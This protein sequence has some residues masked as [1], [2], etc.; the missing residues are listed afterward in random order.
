MYRHLD[1]SALSISMQPSRFP[2]L[3]LTLEE[4]SFMKYFIAI[5]LVGFVAP[6]LGLAQDKPVQLKDLKDKASYSVGLNI[7]TNFKRQNVEL[8]PEALLAGVKDAL[9]G[10]KPLLTQTEVREV[11]A[12]WSKE[13]SEKQK[14]MADKN[15]ADGEKF[16]AANAKK[17]GVKTTP[18]GLQYKV[19]KEGTGAQPKAGDTV[20]VDY[21]GSLIDGT[22]FDSSYKRGQSTTFPVNGV[23]PGWTEALQLMK[24]G[25]KFQLFIPSKLAYGDRV[26]GP[27]IPA[28]S[29]LVF[30][31]ELKG[32]QPAPS[33]GP[34][35]APK[36]S[37]AP[38][39]PPK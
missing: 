11:M 19:L 38:K 2:D 29:T 37:P 28:N 15:L 1:G 32:I 36:T 18:S 26:V 7:G 23:I 20:T 33:A 17:Q 5:V 8:N 10:K 39:P 16:L 31:V 12:S 35:S 4:I 22:E 13:M 27:E 30:E 14:A 34:S 9:S 25:S 21:R 6:A 3:E 24:V